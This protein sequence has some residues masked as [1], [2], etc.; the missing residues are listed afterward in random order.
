MK[1]ELVMCIFVSWMTDED[2]RA[3]EKLKGLVFPK[4]PLPT[5]IRRLLSLCEHL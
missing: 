5:N 2:M 1:N 4:G 3:V